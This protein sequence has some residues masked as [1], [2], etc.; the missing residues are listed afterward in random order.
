MGGIEKKSKINLK[1]NNQLG[2]LSI[3]SCVFFVTL[4]DNL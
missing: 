3:T 4:I 1:K 2:V